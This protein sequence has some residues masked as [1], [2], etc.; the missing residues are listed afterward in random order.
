MPALAGRDDVQ[1]QIVG[2]HVQCLQRQSPLAR[3]E[4]GKCRLGNPRPLADGVAC[5]AAAGDRVAD[6]VAQLNSTISHSVMI[7]M[8]VIL[9]SMV[10]RDDWRWPLPRGT[11][12]QPDG[13]SRSGAN[14]MRLHKAD[15]AARSARGNHFRLV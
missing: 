15:R 1:P 5:P 4:P 8:L 13:E 7:L 10:A 11:R 12:S 14:K 3:H 6:L 9:S 2:Q